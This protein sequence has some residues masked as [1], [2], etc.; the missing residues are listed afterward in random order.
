[1]HQRRT[2]SKQPRQVAQHFGHAH[3]RQ[4]GDV[5]PRLE[6]NLAHARA[7]DADETR[8]RMDC[9]Q[10]RDQFGTEL[11]AGI[12]AGD[13]GENR[14]AVVHLTSA[15]SLRSMNSQNARTSSLVFACSTS[16]A[17]ASSSVLC[18]MYSVR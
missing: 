3:D 6:T 12:L 4:F 17:R 2:Q 8:L 7:A 18:D 15:R 16:A 14:T 1:L 5:V 11:V 13:E 10:C 9:T